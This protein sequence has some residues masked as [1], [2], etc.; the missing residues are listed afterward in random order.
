[1]RDPLTGRAITEE[2]CDQD[3]IDR[4]Y[5]PLDLVVDSGELSADEYT[6]VVYDL[7][8][9]LYYVGDPS[10]QDRERTGI[11]VLLFLAFFF[12]FTYL[13]GREYTKEIH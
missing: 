9:F 3:L 10:R 1:M 2:K 13:L 8:N 4:G 7:T 11:F 12:V 6:Q 5:S